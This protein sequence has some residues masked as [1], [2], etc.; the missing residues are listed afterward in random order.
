MNVDREAI[1]LEGFSRPHDASPSIFACLD[2][3]TY[4]LKNWSVIFHRD[5][6]KRLRK[7]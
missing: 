2:V 4:C 3:R 1:A 7:S 6:L 5:P